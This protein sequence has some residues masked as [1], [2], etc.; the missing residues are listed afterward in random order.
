MRLVFIAFLIFIFTPSTHA[1]RGEFIISI[2]AVA[3][4]TIENIENNEEE[5]AYNVG[6]AVLFE[7]NVNS[8]FGIETGGILIDRQYDVKS[9]SLRLVE[10]VKRLHIPILFRLWPADFVSIAA[11]PFASF[12]IGNTTRTVEI[13]NIVSANLE[14]SADEEAQY[15]LDAA[16]TFNI[17]VYNKTG[18]FIEGRYSSPFEKEDNETSDEATALVG[19]KLSL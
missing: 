2:A 17:A 19:V 12:K 13:G 6:A 18:I 1:E 15:G 9:G 4:N 10:N 7:A 11:G 3:N 16:V 8:Y 14:T 5:K